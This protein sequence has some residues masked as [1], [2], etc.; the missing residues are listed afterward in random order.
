MEIDETRTSDHVRVFVCEQCAQMRASRTPFRTQS[1]GFRA[2]IAAK[3]SPNEPK[4]SI[5]LGKPPR[6]MELVAP[7]CPVDLFSQSATPL[8]G[9]CAG[10]GV[11]IREGLLDPGM[12]ALSVR[13]M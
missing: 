13:F 5:M 11:F 4:A 2:D 6:S 9:R 3:H 10:I 7:Y 12:A 1:C 8:G